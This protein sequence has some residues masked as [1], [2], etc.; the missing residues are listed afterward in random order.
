M[1]HIH[2]Y[3]TYVDFQVL[4]FTKYVALDRFKVF[5]RKEQRERAFLWLLSILV[6]LNA[7]VDT[8]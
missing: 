1:L 8:E 3:Y 6:S 5:W 2:V 7:P 4:H